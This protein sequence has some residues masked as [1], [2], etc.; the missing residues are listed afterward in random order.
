MKSKNREIKRTLLPYFSFL[1]TICLAGMVF[2]QEEKTLEELLNTKIS[3]AI[4]YDQTIFDAPASVTIITSE[5][6]ERYGYRTLDEVFKNISGFYVSSDRTY[7]YLGSRG[8]S[9]PTDYNNRV[10][11]LINGHSLNE[12]ISGSMPLETEL[13]INFDMVDRIEIVRGPSSALYGTSAMFVVINIVTKAGNRVDGFHLFSETG[14]YGRLRGS[15]TFG[16]ELDNGMDISISGLWTDIKGENLYYEEYDD[17]STN[18]GIAKGVD[19]DK[20]YGVLA[21]ITYG[22][23][24]LQGIV[25]SRKKGIP[26]GA[27]EVNFNDPA[28]KTI[29]KHKFI[30]LKFDHKLAADKNIVLRGYLDQYGCDETYPYEIDWLEISSNDWLGGE[31]KFQWDLKSNNR[32]IVGAESQYHFRAKYKAWDEEAVYFDGN[33]PFYIFSLYVQDEYQI[34]KNLSLTFGIRRD[35]YSTVGSSTAP[36][37]AVIYHPFQSSAFK[38]LYGEAFRAPN[39]FEVHYEDEEAGYRPNLNLKPEKIKTMELIWEQQVSDQI[40]GFISLHNYE[41]RDLIDWVVDPEDDFL[42]YQNIGKVKAW[43]LELGFNARLKN[44]LWGYTS[45][46]FQNAT[47]SELKE[48]LTN[49]PK[50]LLK[51]GLSF[52]VFNHFYASAQFL[53]ETERITVYGTSTDPFL[54]SNMHFSSKNLFDHIKVSLSIKNLFNTK[55]KFPGGYE[56]IQDAII[57]VG[58][59]FIVKVKYTF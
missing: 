49:S 4:K 32:L 29:D 39:I 43:G 41:M 18:Y 14:S 45:Y 51:A 7:A 57:Q 3:T 36:R 44:G 5:D 12:M 33:F 59:N 21:K 6:I 28:A 22:D 46:S 2:A 17:P 37:A 9:R 52:P 38:L 30:E 48:N 31:F 42:Q 24:S 26:T 47:D 11:L 34:K 35:E 58:R 20:N 54:L 15:A 16:K 40:F 19:Y 25:T 23:F 8:F 1:I 50:H 10:L 55:Y 27:W 13:A 53:Y 56:H